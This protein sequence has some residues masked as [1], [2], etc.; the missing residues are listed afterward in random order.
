MKGSSAVK[1]AS[2]LLV[3]VTLVAYD[4]RAQE[5][6]GIAPEIVEVRP[7]SAREWSY[8]TIHG[9]NLRSAGGSCAIKIGDLSAY[10]RECSDEKA[11]AVVPWGAIGGGIGK[12][13][14]YE[15][16]PAETATYTI[17]TDTGPS[18]FLT[19]LAVYVWGGLG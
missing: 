8:V 13:V 16:N 7:T 3:L 9:S 4:A 12:T 6:S 18:S 10:V 11:T 14:W 2:L 15:F 5:A 1:F 19:V 17:R